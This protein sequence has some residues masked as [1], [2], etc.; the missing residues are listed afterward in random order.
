MASTTTRPMTVE[1]FAKLPECAEYICE[2]HRGGVVKMTRPVF[3]HIRVQHRLQRFLADAAGHPE[4]V[5]MEAPFRPV[6]EF[7]L[8]VADVAY[9]PEERWKSVPASGYFFG[10]P[11]LVI[12]ILSPSNTAAAMLE[13]E[14]ICLENGCREFWIVDLDRKQVKISTPEGRT[15]T[16][17]AGSS[18]PLFFAPGKALAVNAIFE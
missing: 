5:Y 15:A 10:V 14:Q 13:R 8:R 12:E 17:K 16:Y 2:L 4:A 1:E 7:E 11:E 18:I 9:A 6:P 3:G